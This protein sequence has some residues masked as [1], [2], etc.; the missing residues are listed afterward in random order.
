[1]PGQN[2][3][4]N[5]PNWSPECGQPACPTC[6]NILCV[7]D[8]TEDDCPEGSFLTE[9]KIFGCCPA[10]V[11][12]REYGEIC[13]G[14]DWKDDSNKATPVGLMFGED[15]SSD[16]STYPDSYLEYA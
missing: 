12:Y 9:N 14:V 10:C 1:M 3:N 13:P 2:I 8:L 6:E 5:W 15:I 4:C 7:E 11:K 16:L